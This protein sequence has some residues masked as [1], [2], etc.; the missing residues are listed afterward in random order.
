MNPRVWFCPR[1]GGPQCLCTPHLLGSGCGGS[2]ASCPYCQECRSEILG[3]ETHLGTWVAV[4]AEGALLHGS[5]TVQ[6]PAPQTVLFWH[7]LHFR[8]WEMTFQ[9]DGKMTGST[10]SPTPGYGVVLHAKRTGCDSSQPS[11]TPG[12][13]T[14][15]SGCILT[16][17][18]QRTQH[19]TTCAAL[20]G[21]PLHPT[22]ACTAGPGLEGTA[23][24]I[25]TWHQGVP[26][27]AA[28]APALC[29]CSGMTD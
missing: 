4:T 8:S 6:A 10:E 2:S 16:S 20:L 11:A 13:T 27:A 18:S 24:L 17:A 5:T 1:G 23:P 29:C 26:G 9:Q 14:G 3:L 15:T 12:R 21:S 7:L 25:S 28:L 22:G 19:T